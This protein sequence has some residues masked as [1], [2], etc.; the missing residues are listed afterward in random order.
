MRFLVPI[1]LLGAVASVNAFTTGGKQKY[2]ANYIMSLDFREKSVHFQ[3]FLILHFPAP[4]KDGD[5]TTKGAPKDRDSCLKI[6]E[7]DCDWDSDCCDGLK[8]DSDWGW[9]TDYCVAG[10]ETKNYEWAAWGEW[11]ECSVSCG[12]TGTRSRSRQCI[13][14]QKGGLECPRQTDTE[15]EECHAPACWTD[16]GDWSACSI[17]W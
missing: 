2:L 12:S 11:S 6:S 4:P 3:L 16:F 1:A 7:G 8:C 10:S 17:S 5:F 14:P 13:G 9:K 15:T